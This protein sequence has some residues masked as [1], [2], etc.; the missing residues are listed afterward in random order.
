MKE[1]GEQIDPSTHRKN[2]IRVVGRSGESSELDLQGIRID[3]DISGLYQEQR[4]ETA[5][6]AVI[7]NRSLSFFFEDLKVLHQETPKL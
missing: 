5:L 6:L 4:N 3:T 1:Y 2:Y 7:L